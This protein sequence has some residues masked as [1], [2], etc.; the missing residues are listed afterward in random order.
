[1]QNTFFSFIITKIQEYL[2]QQDDKTTC[3]ALCILKIPDLAVVLNT[4]GVSGA[5][6]IIESTSNIIMQHTS[7]QSLI[8]PIGFDTILLCIP[9]N[10]KAY[11]KDALGAI[12][13]AIR[14]CSHGIL[15]QDTFLR[16]RCGLT[17]IQPSQ[18]QEMLKE[19]IAN[20]YVALYECEASEETSYMWSQQKNGYVAQ[21][22]SQLHLANYI[23]KAIR[24]KRLQ[25]AFQPIIDSKTK[26]HGFY[27]G[28]LRI[29]TEEGRTVSV[30][31][32]IPI[33][34]S[35]GLISEIDLLVLELAANELKMT[36]TLKLSIN[37]SN[38]STDDA[39]WLTKAKTLLPSQDIASRLIVEITETGSKHEVK[40]LAKFTDTMHQIGC[41]VAI[42]DFGAGYTS[43]TELKSINADLIKVDGSF[44]RD[45]I[46]NSHNRIFVETLI[47]LAHDIGMKA[48]VEFVETEAI[49][50]ILLAMGT[51]YM[52]GNHFSPAVNYKFW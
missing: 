8:L 42:D 33:A 13:S 18:N 50:N 46:E 4:D 20:C 23:H 11:H 26:T 48:V 32:F 47:R 39:T 43:F 27:E 49:A 31:P 3:Y 30:G 2:L 24:Q 29:R 44:I 41:S 19:S 17:L 5:S 7:N 28:L 25:L 51:D 34:E 22:A 36:P 1:M 6:S 10:Q 9:S 12:L 37:I 38:M 21:K 52:Q 14:S 40:R 16:P 15:Q 35:M 45:L